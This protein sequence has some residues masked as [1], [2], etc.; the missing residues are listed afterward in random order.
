MIVIYIIVLLMSV[1][2]HEIAHAYTARFFGDNT[3]AEQGRLTLNPFVHLDLLG[4]IILPLLLYVTSAGVLFGWAKPVPVNITRLKNTKI[5]IFLVALAGPVSNFLLVIF[6]LFLSFLT[7]HPFFTQVLFYAITLNFILAIFNLI[8]CP[9][10]DGSKLI[11]TF[12]PIKWAD[13]FYRYEM[14]G[15]VLLF[16]LLYF[17]ALDHIFSIALYLSNKLFVLRFSLGGFYA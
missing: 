11:A 8:P 6:C 17:G 14:Y 13:F 9:P 16:A 10:L 5:A 12:L 1:V 15:T 3:A 4:S 2:I 7:S